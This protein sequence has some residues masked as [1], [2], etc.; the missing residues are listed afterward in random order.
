MLDSLFLQILNMSYTASY[1]ILFV[2]FVRLFLQKTPKIF[3]YILWSVV[4]FRLVCPFSFESMLSILPSKVNPIPSNIA[5]MQN[6]EIDTGIA[7]LNNSINPIL[8]KAHPAASINP[9]QIGLLI[10]EIIWL[11]G[12]IILLTYNFLPYINSKNH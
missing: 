9:L 8:P 12:I 7:L 6:P 3:S 1:V 5:F 11:I 10:G 2:L 4:F